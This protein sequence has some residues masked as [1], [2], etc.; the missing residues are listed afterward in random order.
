MNQ[1]NIFKLLLIILLIGNNHG[2]QCRDDCQCNSFWGSANDVI[3][4]ALLLGLITDQST[5]SSTETTAN[6]NTTF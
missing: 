3:L 1:E 5:L 6:T 4:M 2:N